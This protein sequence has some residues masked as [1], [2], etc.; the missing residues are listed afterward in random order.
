MRY[1]DE[2]LMN[3]IN[4]SPLCSI[5]VRLADP[6]SRYRRSSGRLRDHETQF[7][8]LLRTAAQGLERRRSARTGV[9]KITF[10]GAANLDTLQT[11]AGTAS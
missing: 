4:R 6:R 8:F 2:E 10:S 7:Q 1:F 5:A 9:L 11:I 3:K